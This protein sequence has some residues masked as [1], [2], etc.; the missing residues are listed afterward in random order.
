MELEL[1][2][3]LGS[4]L[5][6]ELELELGSELELELELELEGWSPNT[7]LELAGAGARAGA[8]LE[9]RALTAA[10]HLAPLGPQV[11]SSVCAQERRT[12]AQAFCG[13]WG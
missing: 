9:Q 3:E 4:E 6:L 8:S 11:V 1:E 2:L 10:G 13:P 7:Y 12:S 5:E